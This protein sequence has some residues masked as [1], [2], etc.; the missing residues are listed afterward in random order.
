MLHGLAFDKVLNDRPFAVDFGH[1]VHRGHI[2]RG[3]LLHARRIECLVQNVRLGVF[4]V[5]QF[6]ERFALS[7][8][9]LF[10]RFLNDFRHDFFLPHFP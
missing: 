8:N 7:V 3:A 10:L 2:E 4:V 9:G 1:F 5:E 6:D